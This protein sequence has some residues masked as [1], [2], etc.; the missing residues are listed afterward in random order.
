MGY[1]QMGRQ[2]VL[3][4]LQ[5]YAFERRGVVT[6]K[7]FVAETGVPESQVRKHFGSWSALVKECGSVNDERDRK[8]HSDEALWKA[9]HG[10]VEKRGRF[11]TNAEIDR[12]SPFSSRTYYARFGSQPR[13]RMQYARWLQARQASGGRQSPVEMEGRR[14]VDVRW[15]RER[16]GKFRV[17]FELHSSDFRGRVA[18]E[19]DLLVV[20]DH[21]WLACPVKVLRMSELLPEARDVQPTEWVSTEPTR[22]ELYGRMPWD[23]GSGES[24]SP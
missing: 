4:L 1:R 8:R 15:M 17:T 10:L 9:Y 21:D 7:G 6:F 11:P 16:W 22:A 3:E 14:P 13:V 5:E 12:Y 18:H 19:W 20:L 2:D 24:S 23:A